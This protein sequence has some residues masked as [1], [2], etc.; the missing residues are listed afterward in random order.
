MSQS[1][2]KPAGPPP[3]P[4]IISIPRAWTA[5]EFQLVG[6]LFGITLGFGYFVVCHATRQARR[7]NTF[8]VLVW[9]GVRVTYIP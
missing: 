8:T 1:N 6:V 9:V 7:M 3:P 5:A 4:K 2:S